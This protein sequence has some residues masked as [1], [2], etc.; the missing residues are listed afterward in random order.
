MDMDSRHR[1]FYSLSDYY[2]ET[3]GEKVYKLAIDAGFTCPN[4][5]GSLGTRG[6]IF[7]SSK[8]SGEFG[9]GMA[10][11]LNT[12]KELIKAKT[13]AQTFIVYFQSFTN[14]YGPVKKLK[15][16]YE[17]ALT[18]PSVV[19][20]SIATR[21]DCLNDEIIEMLYDLNK[22]T[23]IYI[24]LGLQTIHKETAE[25]IRRGYPQSVFNETLKSL[26]QA[27]IPVIPHLI[28]GLPNETRTDMIE[29]VRYVSSMP[30]QGIKIHML[31]ILRD[32]DLYQYYLHSPFPIF[33]EEEYIHTLIDCL[34]YI[35]KHVVIHRLTG[36][37]PK[38]LLV[39]PQWSLNKRHV[40]NQITKFFKQR[41][42]YQGKA[43]EA[44]TGESHDKS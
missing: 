43:L 17:R 3:Y 14:T 38:N 1:P 30:I 31:H 16:L 21:P 41:N 28:L 36:D 33:S 7:C 20:L 4:R 25:F 27:S 39:E 24:E 19:G 29:S 26:H 35:P 10:D 34:E 40:L 18:D 44:I 13:S 22:R 37:G 12:A 11:Q 9:I 2:K 23:D 6:C 42:T 5:D 15:S 32:T 8:G